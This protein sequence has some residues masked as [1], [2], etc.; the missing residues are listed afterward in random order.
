MLQMLSWNSECITW[1]DQGAGN[2][3]GKENAW[4]SAKAA[5][6]YHMYDPQQII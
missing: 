3:L 6:T 2:G 5:A 1:E 4:F